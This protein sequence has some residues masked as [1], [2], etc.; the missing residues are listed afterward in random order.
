MTAVQPFPDVP[1]WQE[2]PE[3]S[4]RC[5]DLL[6]RL[7]A[8]TWRPHEATMWRE[9][10]DAAKRFRIHPWEWQNLICPA[11]AELAAANPNCRWPVYRLPHCPSQILLPGCER[12]YS[13]GSGYSNV[14]QAYC[15]CPEPDTAAWPHEFYHRVHWVTHDGKSA[16]CH[17]GPGEQPPGSGEYGG[18][19]GDGYVCESCAPLLVTERLTWDSKWVSGPG[20]VGDGPSWSHPLKCDCRCCYCGDVAKERRGWRLNGHPATADSKCPNA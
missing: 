20:H 4:Q 7:Q 11:W 5:L 10:R 3:R 6:D 8:G 15:T 9:D 2:P 19:N 1:A 18:T 12:D 16:Y 17:C 13:S 14:I